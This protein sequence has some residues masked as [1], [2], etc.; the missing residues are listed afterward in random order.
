MAVKKMNCFLLFVALLLSIEVVNG[1]ANGVVRLN[2]NGIVDPSNTEGVIEVY[3][4]NRWG[5]I[6]YTSESSIF[7]AYVPDVV[8]HQLGYTGGNSGSNSGVVNTSPVFSLVG[9]EDSYL[10][11]MQCDCYIDIPSYCTYADNLDI[12]CYATRIWDN[13]YPGMV[14]LQGGN[15]TG[16]GI[17]Q[18]YCNN[19]WAAV[20]NDGDFND[21]T[22]WTVC[23]Q[24]GY[25]VFDV[26]TTSYTGKAW[27]NNVDCSTDDPDKDVPSCLSKCS[28][29]KCPSSTF[30]CSTALN[31]TCSHGI[32]FDPGGIKDACKFAHGLSVGAIAGIVSGCLVGFI[33]LVIFA[34]L[35]ICCCKRCC[36]SPAPV[37]GRSTER[38][39]ILNKRN[40]ATN[41]SK[42]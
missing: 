36:S 1:Q 37:E 21:D 31:V 16:Q 8:C 26:G 41:Y 3:Y 12:T 28:G 9:C 39:N 34:T 6:C 33:I 29:G 40:T 23:T 20:C 25:N 11:I 18:V 30:S 27:L 42:V 22:G 38:H 2:F 24:L 7:Y 5:S 4:N 35:C 15:Y 13:P 10:T 14:R 19:E 17:V 32:R